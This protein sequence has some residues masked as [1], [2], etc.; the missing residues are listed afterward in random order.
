MLRRRQITTS[1]IRSIP[2]ILDVVILLI[3][4]ILMF[5]IIGFLIFSGVVGKYQY[6][7]SIFAE[8]R[9]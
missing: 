2:K 9:A 3:L 5:A 1:I 7:T 6:E 8:V 4:T